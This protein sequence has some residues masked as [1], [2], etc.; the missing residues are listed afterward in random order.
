M[1]D[2]KQLCDIVAEAAELHGHVWRRVRFLKATQTS[3]NIATAA[4]AWLDAILDESTFLH[5]Q[6]VAELASEIEAL[7][8]AIAR[9]VAQVDADAAAALLWRF[10]SLADNI[11]N[12]TTEEG[13]EV[14]QVFDRACADVVR[15]AISTGA[16]ARVFAA[17]VR[18]AL[19]SDG[20]G[21]FGQLMAVIN[22]TRATHP[23]FVTEIIAFLQTA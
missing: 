1:T 17:D 18:E 14:G 19:A 22:V 8:L 10:F 16:P 9:D 5:A 20:Y 6:D 23:A 21:E 3:S 12:R 7:R 2:P 11:Y 4:R 13:W 15:L